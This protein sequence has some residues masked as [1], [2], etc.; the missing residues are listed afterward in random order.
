MITTGINVF[1]SRSRNFRRGSI[2]LFVVIWVFFLNCSF[3]F[4]F[5]KFALGFVVFRF[6][7]FRFLSLVV[8]ASGFGVLFFFGDYWV[9]FF[10]CCSGV[11]LERFSG[12][13]V[14][15]FFFFEVLYF[16]EMF[17]CF[18]FLL[19]SEL[20]WVGFCLFYGFIRVWNSVWNSIWSRGVL[21]LNIC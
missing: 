12:L 8:F 5:V 11:L 2:L 9:F 1:K 20:G 6:Y 17:G 7:G 15:C 19:E 16:F 4:G 14:F 3:G 10:G 13:F 18:L 21:D